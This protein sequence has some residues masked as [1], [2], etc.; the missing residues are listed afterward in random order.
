MYM[1][2]NSKYCY[3]IIVIGLILAFIIYS[4]LANGIMNTVYFPF[5]FLFMIA[6][7]I[8][9]LLSLLKANMLTDK[10][11]AFREAYNCCGNI[12]AIGGAGII[13]ISFFTSLLE[14]TAGNILFYI[15]VALCFFFLTFLCGGICCF[16]YLYNRCQ[17]DYLYQSNYLYQNPHCNTR[18]CGVSK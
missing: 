15:G 6:V 10:S 17:E 18:D 2:N 9:T 1:K 14:N 7:G 3:T 12:S 16:L 13:M 5:F 11:R 4:L 8:I